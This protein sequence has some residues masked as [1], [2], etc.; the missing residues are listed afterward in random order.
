[1]GKEGRFWHSAR[2]TSSRLP[3]HQLSKLSSS[4]PC[5]RSLC[6]SCRQPRP[7]GKWS[8]MHPDG[9]SRPSTARKVWAAVCRLPRATPRTDH[10]HRH[11]QPECGRQLA[12]SLPGRQRQ[13]DRHGEHPAHHGSLIPHHLPRC[14]WPNGGQLH[15]SKFAR[16]G[17]RTQ[18]RDASGRLTGSQATNA[19]P[20]G[21]FTGTQRDASGRLTGGSTRSVKCQ[22][23]AVVPATPPGMKN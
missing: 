9:S 16:T 17:S 4:R 7:A 3:F 20:S 18:F 11:H 15:T 13:D 12:N 21:S 8:V 22:G 23:I 10:Q 1:M 5:F 2:M 14:E 6:P 19:S